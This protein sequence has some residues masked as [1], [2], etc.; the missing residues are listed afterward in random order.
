MTINVYDNWQ[1]WSNW[2]R[3]HRQKCCVFYHT[4][5]DDYKATWHDKV[6]WEWMNVYKMSILGILSNLKNENQKWD[7]WRSEI[8]VENRVLNLQHI[9][10]NVG[11]LETTQH[12]FSNQEALTHREQQTFLITGLGEIK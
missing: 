5:H 3:N 7:F 11:I 4:A 10:I 6:E 8:A 12:N 9:P 1:F 2:W